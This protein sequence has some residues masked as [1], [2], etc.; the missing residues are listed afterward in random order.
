[1]PRRNIKIQIEKL[2]ALQRTVAAEFNDFGYVW[3]CDAN[4]RSF[5]LKHLAKMSDLDELQLQEKLKHFASTHK[6]AISQDFMIGG[7]QR[8]HGGTD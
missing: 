2:V 1:M 7:C 4:V 3:L 6:Q 5:S 8:K